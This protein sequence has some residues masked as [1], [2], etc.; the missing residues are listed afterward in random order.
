MLLIDNLLQLVEKFFTKKLHM[1]LLDKLIFQMKMEIRLNIFSI[2]LHVGF[3]TLYFLLI[4]LL[5]SSYLPFE[6]A[7][8]RII[9]NGIVM[10]FAF[11]FNALILVNHLLEQ[12]KYAAFFTSA[13]LVVFVSTAFRFLLLKIFERTELS[14]LIP[15]ST[16]KL[17]IFSFVNQFVVVT[18]ST[19]YQLLQNR[20]NRERAKQQLLTMQSEAQIQFLKAQINPHFLFNT[21]NNIYALSVIRSEKTPE[22][23]LKLSD[24]LRYVIYGGREKQVLL[25]EETDHIKKFIQLFQMKSEHELNITMQ[26]EGSPS[27]LYIEPMILIPVVENCFKHTDFDS[28]PNAYIKII[29]T[30]HDKYLKFITLNTKDDGNKQKDKTGGVGLENIKKRL[31]LNYFNKHELIIQ[32]KKQIFEVNLSMELDNEKDTNAFS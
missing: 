32:N 22:M 8:I 3:W 24:L 11:Y 26:I 2:S 25:S 20:V 21:L 13:T 28:N 27:G 31:Q 17:A 23:I 9:L 5:V 12:K 10:A 30:V 19:L 18:G 4:I 6:Q 16:V 7:I 15:E 1:I 14:F 29:L